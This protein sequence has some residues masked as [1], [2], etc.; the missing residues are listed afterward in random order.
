[1]SFR[2]IAAPDRGVARWAGRDVASASNASGTIIIRNRIRRRQLCY[3]DCWTGREPAF[4]ACSA[5]CI[6]FFVP[7][8]STAPSILSCISTTFHLLRFLLLHRSATRCCYPYPGNLAKRAAPTFYRLAALTSNSLG[9]LRFPFLIRYAS[10]DSLDRVQNHAALP[11]PLLL[12]LDDPHPR[13]LFRAPRLTSYDDDTAG[14][15]W[16]RLVIVR[17]KSTSVNTTFDRRRSRWLP[18]CRS[19][20]LFDV[21][22]RARDSS[23]IPRFHLLVKRVPT[24]REVRGS[25]IVQHRPATGRSRAGAALRWSGD[26]FKWT[27]LRSLTHYHTRPRYEVYKQTQ[28]TRG[29]LRQRWRKRWSGQERGVCAD[30][31]KGATA[32]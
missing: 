13:M 22:L 31:A 19:L 1:M 26:E 21:R 27:G 14:P 23:V 32:R 5:S 11:L 25:V 12:T 6:V 15:R 2:G 9:T 30:R 10:A 3:R 29:R 18:P 24:S 16:R 28:A 7:L 4:V 8:L 17:V 20:S